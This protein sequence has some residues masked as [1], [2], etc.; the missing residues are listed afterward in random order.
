[1]INLLL[2]TKDRYI[3]R[4]RLNLFLLRPGFPHPM[5]DTHR[6]RLILIILSITSR[7]T[8]AIK[9]LILRRDKSN[10]SSCSGVAQDSGL[11]RVMRS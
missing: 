10:D 4:K 1:M 8:P 3:F 6:L 5:G 11:G 9:P 7:L 2:F